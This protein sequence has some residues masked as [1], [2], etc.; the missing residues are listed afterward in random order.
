MWCSCGVDTSRCI[1]GLCSA[2]RYRSSTGSCSLHTSR[3]TPTKRPSSKGPAAKGP[4]TKGLRRMVR[5]TKCLAARGP[6]EKVPKQKVRIPFFL[7]KLQ[8]NVALRTI[9]F[10]A[11]NESYVNTT[12]P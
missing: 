3:Y 9:T 6:E 12:G 8:K 7:K 1:T 10:F 2:D 5:D 11:L 4:A